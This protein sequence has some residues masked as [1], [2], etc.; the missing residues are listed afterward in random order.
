MDIVIYG[1]SDNLD[2]N[3]VSPPLSLYPLCTVYI[4]YTILYKEFMHKELRFDKQILEKLV[5][6]KFLCASLHEK[7]INCCRDMTPGEWKTS[8]KVAQ[9]CQNVSEKYFTPVI[10]ILPLFGL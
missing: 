4:G 3:Y 7:L 9:M 10:R 8:Q 6:A 5:D 2:K 1:Y